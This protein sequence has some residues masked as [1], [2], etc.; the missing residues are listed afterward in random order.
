MTPVAATSASIAAEPPA[1]PPRAEV[2]GGP[3][4]ELPPLGSAAAQARPEAEVAPPAASASAAARSLDGPAPIRGTDWSWPLA[5]DHGLRRDVGGQGEF[6]APRSH[7]QHNGLD[8]LAPLET[9]ILSVCDGKSRA[10]ETGS[11]GK[12]VQV[13]CKVPPSL[14]GSERLF[15]SFHYSHL[16]TTTYRDGDWFLVKRGDRLGTV[17]KTGNARGADIAPHLHLEVAIQ[18]TDGRAMGEEHSGR[19]QS[20]SAA[21]DLFAGSLERCA[22]HYGLTVPTGAR[23]ARR[24]DPFLA[25][26]CAGAGKPPYRAPRSA[27]LQAASVRWS[28]RYHAGYDVDAATRAPAPPAPPAAS[29]AEPPPAPPAV[30]SAP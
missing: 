8:L 19:D 11:F 26:T 9:P 17:G 14:A 27:A 21:A 1:P 4:P 28:E 29:G 5:V 7:G 22:A 23:R 13:V 30:A 18:P 16:A 6:L 2:A 25:L 20:S 24:F 15:A 12:W 10:G 3:R